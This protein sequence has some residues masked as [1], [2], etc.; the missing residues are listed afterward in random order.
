METRSIISFVPLLLHGGVLVLLLVTMRAH[1][2]EN[3]TTFLK[4]FLLLGFTHILFYAFSFLVASLPVDSLKESL[5]M[6]I[7][8]LQPITYFFIILFYR[9]R[10]EQ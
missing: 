1:F 7:S 10:I 6:A 4:C 2:R 5:S 9:H 3:K 8:Y